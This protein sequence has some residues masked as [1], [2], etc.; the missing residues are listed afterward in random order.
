MFDSKDTRVLELAYQTELKLCARANKYEE[1]MRL[2]EEMKLQRV[3][4][5]AVTFSILLF[6][7][8]K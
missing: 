2:F 1:M 6:A 4:P 8:S 3:Q 7:L 5:R